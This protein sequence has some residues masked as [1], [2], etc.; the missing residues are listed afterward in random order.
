MSTVS[1]PFRNLVARHE[2]AWVVDTLAGRPRRPARRLPERQFLVRVS[3]WWGGT[4]RGLPFGF[5]PLRPLEVME[6][7]KA[8]CARRKAM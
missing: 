8:F 2:L 1:A 7:M 4:H 6:R 3:V 5:Q